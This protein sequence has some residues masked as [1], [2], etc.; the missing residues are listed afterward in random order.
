MPSQEPAEKK[1]DDVQ[2]G[3]G[4]DE[5]TL[6]LEKNRVEH[7]QTGYEGQE[8]ACI[9]VIS[10][11][12]VGRMVKLGGG[13]VTLGRHPTCDLELDDL[14]VSREHARVERDDDSVYIQDLDSSNGTFLNGREI[15][16][17]RELSDGD[18]LSVG[19]STILKFTYQDPFEETFQRKMYEASLRDSLTD[20]YNRKYLQSYL[21]SELSF[22]ERHS[23]VLSLILYDFDDFERINNRYGHL[24]GDTVLVEVADMVRTS[25]REEDVFARFGGDEFAVISRK[26][27][28]DDAETFA[29]RLREMIAEKTFSYEGDT[30]EITLSLGVASTDYLEPSNPRDFLTFA[31]TA[32]YR[33]KDDGGDS[34]RLAGAEADAD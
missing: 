3:E 30:F 33:A 16:R 7:L 11:S 4:E 10:G 18:K 31:D 15:E 28:G 34:V 29:D 27:G 5:D 14:G 1:E 17:R 32:L 19:A 8:D 24:A 12:Q 20:A 21:R 2:P 6:Q 25:I 23:T 13:G 22:S 26:I 9:I